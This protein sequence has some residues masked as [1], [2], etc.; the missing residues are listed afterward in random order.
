[1]TLPQSHTLLLQLD[2]GVLT[3]TLNRPSV[4]NAMS[5]QMV[6]ELTTVA[7]YAESNLSLRALVLRG[8]GGH[9]SAGADLKDMAL[10][11][12][13]PTTAGQDPIADTNAAFGQL[14]LAYA[15]CTLPVI[16]VIEGA[17]M[18]GGF[19]LSCVADVALAASSAVF[20]LPETSLGII[21]AQIAPFLLERLSYA[22]AKRLCVTGGKIDAHE[23]LAIRLVHEVHDT[24]E[25]LEQALQATLARIRQCAPNANRVTKALL[26]RARSE[27]VGSLIQEAAR[28]FSA[29]LTG[30]EG[31][32][33]S[34]A[35]MQKR[36]PSWANKGS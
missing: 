29:A 33:G 1:M 13:Q 5:L 15:R 24:P 22:E 4:R 27:P 28:L 21:P 32:E 2:D 8:A 9:F 26:V 25:A 23:A 11:R 16:A 6:H 34:L 10:A 36:A 35:F 30:P 20:R 18:G 31:Q 19:G 3:V 12:A 14:C 7:A 17:V